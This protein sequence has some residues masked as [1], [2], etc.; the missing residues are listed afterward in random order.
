MMVILNVIHFSGS[1][2]LIFRLKI[3]SLL[4]GSLTQN[5]I[6][7]INYKYASMLFVC[8]ISKCTQLPA[9]G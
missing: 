2:K 4:L 5:C 9:G 3:F 8:S 6:L 1:I 7:A